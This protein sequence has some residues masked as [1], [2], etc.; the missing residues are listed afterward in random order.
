MKTM[1]AATVVGWALGLWAATSSASETS[2]A[3]EAA[4]TLAEQVCN[5]CHGPA[6]HSSNSAIPK[7]AAQ[8]PLYLVAKMRQFRD[9]SLAKPQGHLDIL[10]MSLL[11]D[12]GANALARYYARQSP[13]AGKAGDPAVIAEGGKVFAQGIAEQNIP[14]CSVCHG[15]RAAGRWIFPRLAGQH[16]EYVQRQME[17]I[18]QNV[19][20]AT[21]M[22]GILKTMT[23]DQMHSVA[24]YLQSK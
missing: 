6:G 22:H 23:P 2:E 7:L 24:V 3:D 16:A 20:D 12:P 17:Q 5:G 21:V 1:L 10:G 9:R 14:A 13:P 8:R 11:D 19:R 4:A 18:Q 15:P